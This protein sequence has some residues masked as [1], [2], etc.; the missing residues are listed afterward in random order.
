MVPS[1]NLSSSLNKYIPNH[2]YTLNRRDMSPQT[3]L[4][5]TVRRLRISIT[6]LQHSFRQHNFRN[7]SR[8]SRRLR[9]RLD[10]GIL[11]LLNTILSALLNPT[12][13]CHRTIMAS[14]R[15]LLLQFNLPN[16]H[17][18]LLHLNQPISRHSHRLN[19]RLP[20]LP[21]QPRRHRPRLQGLLNPI[22]IPARIPIS[23]IFDTRMAAGS[24][25]ASHGAITGASEGTSTRAS[26]R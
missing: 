26:P 2:R 15:H 9:L 12:P 23:L 18:S 14:Q 10:L 3:F 4:K 1:S 6:R 7:N 17:H 13:T 24:P 19:L 22:S 21:L 20:L 8:H 5:P 11:K 16:S 25:P